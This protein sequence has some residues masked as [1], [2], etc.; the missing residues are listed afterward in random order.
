MET[1]IKCRQIDF[2]NLLKLQNLSYARAGRLFLQ[3]SW[4]K[5]GKTNIASGAN[6]QNVRN[7][8]LKIL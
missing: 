7:I 5:A 3:S 2:L 6:S 1:N 8:N 4:K